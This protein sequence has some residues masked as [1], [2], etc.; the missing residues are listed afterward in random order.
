MSENPSF[1]EE[2]M[3]RFVSER[4]GGFHRGPAE[5]VP[6]ESFSPAELEKLQTIK[7]WQGVRGWLRGRAYDSRPR[8]DAYIE[9]NPERVKA[10]K[11][12]HD[13]KARER[14]YLANEFVAVDFEGQDYLG[15]VINRPNGNG[16]SIPYD[17]H[18]LFLG[19]ASSSDESREPEWLTH[20]ETTDRDKRPLD[21]RAVLDWLVHLPSKFSDGAIFVM[22]SFSYDV[23]HLLRHLR[24]DKAWQIFKE[25]RYDKDRTK[26][27]KVRSRVFCGEPFDEFVMKYRNRKQLDIWKLRDPAHPYLRDED[28]HYVLDKSGYK[29]MDTIAHIT[30]FDTHPFFQQSFVDAMGFLVKTGKARRSDFDFME[31]MKKKRGRF[32]LE[33]LAQIKH[34]TA[35]ELRYLALGLTELRNILHELRLDSAPDMKPIHLNNWYGPGAVASAVL[36]NLDIIKNHYDDDICATDPSPQQIAAHHAFSAGNIQLMKVGHAPGLGLHSMDI[37][38]A[39]PHAIAQLPSLSG[40]RWGRM[41][42]G[43]RYQNLAELK[44]VIEASSIVSMF[45]LDYQFPLYEHFDGD[46]WKR[47]YIPWYPLFFRS[48]TGAIFYPRRG[49]GWYMR[50][51]ALAAIE[52]LERYAPVAKWRGDGTPVTKQWELKDTR[53]VVREAWIFVPRDPSEKPFALPLQEIYGQRMRYK[54]AVPYDAREKFYKLP[55]NSIYGK[56]AQRVGGSQTKDGWKAPPT[57]NPYYAAAITA[58]CRRRLVQAGL[59]DPHAVVA[60]MTDGSV[61]TRR[62]E[63]LPNVVNEGEESKL[64]DWEYA[65]VQGGTFLHAGVYSMRKA[66]KEL[67]KT[68]GVDPKRVSPNEAAGRLLVEKALEAMEKEYHPDIPIAIFLPI[69][70]LVTIGQALTSCENNRELWAAGLAGRW[71]PPIDSPH[72]LHR[73]IHLEK[74][75]TKRRWIPGR[76]DDWQTRRRPD[77]MLR[78]ANRCVTLVPTIPAENPEPDGTRSAMYKPDWIDPDL[79]ESVEE[80]DEQEAIKEGMF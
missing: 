10:A 20:P 78:L 11:I 80:S 30:L 70:D 36:K 58:N 62:L 74:L 50:D 45:Y 31:D 73:A 18:R 65:P 27:R 61:T 76:E 5:I 1:D 56:M 28:G 57:A 54:R 16:G 33:P 32:S 68:R 41:E 40:G 69:R 67:T 75:G 60:F 48:R 66:G 24:F 71:A 21:P 49:E 51:D 34:Y 9:N 29:I 55:P 37:A 25:E 15:N 63:G 47:I 35:L 14:N 12:R 72:A 22:Y 23:T 3:A 64:G 59:V 44:A 4:T 53:F 42:K 8:L 46:A 38:S 77:G 7:T 79:G 2:H 26:R 17:D 13:R 39:Y 6:G 43:V 52:F 19:G